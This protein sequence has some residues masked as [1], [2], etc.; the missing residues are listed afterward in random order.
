MKIT[1]Y[2]IFTVRV[3]EHEKVKKDTI[4]NFFAPT[5][6]YVKIYSMNIEKTIAYH[7]A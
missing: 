7:V 3:L 1:A 5:S 2:T 4:Q 6:L